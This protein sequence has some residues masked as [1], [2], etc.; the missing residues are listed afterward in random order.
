M[1]Q[2]KAR[3]ILLRKLLVRGRNHSRL[4]MALLSLCFGLYLLLLSVMVYTNYRDILSGKYNKNTINGTYIVINKKISNED[5][6]TEQKPALFDGKE[7]RTLA[8]LHTVRD[9]GMFSSAMFPVEVQ[10]KGITDS[11][12]TNL[13]LEAVPDRFIDNKPTDWYWRYT[14]AEVPVIV[15]SEFMNLYNFGY[16]PNQSVP[17]LTRATIKTLIFDLVIGT[18][19]NKQYFKA[20]V[21]GFSDRIS[22]ILVPESFIKYGNEQA[23]VTEETFPSRLILLV[24][25]PSDYDF[26]S[27][28]GAHD[29]I[30]NYELLRWNRLRDVLNV[31]TMGIGLFACILI[32]IGI[33]LLSLFAELILLKASNNFEILLQLGYS[34]AYLSRFMLKRY[35]FILFAVIATVCAAAIITQV[36]IAKYLLTIDITLYT[37]PVWEVWVVLLIALIVL[38]TTWFFSIK[39]RPK[40]KAL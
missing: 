19:V 21:V 36:R 40:N 22:S 35:L 32:V 1:K 9:I 24:S 4:W 12:S 30:I 17:Q 27:F 15:S 37:F 11:F 34:H 14:S 2:K 16:A 31:V 38:G 33:Y 20:R 18:G 8:S 7:I 29:Y 6:I 5:K 3:K 39:P 28:I 23:G 10:L 26:V 25:D 13:F